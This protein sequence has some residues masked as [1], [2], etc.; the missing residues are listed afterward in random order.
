MAA[1][2][3]IL[4]VA[5]GA[6]KL[7]VL[8]VVGEAGLIVVTGVVEAVTLFVR[9]AGVAVTLSV[10]LTVDVTA[11]LHSGV[12]SSVVKTEALDS[13]FVVAVVGVALM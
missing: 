4:V 11:A 6:G 3:V 12:P 13:A 2:G 5:K 9:A 1:V 7:E 8:L 10:L